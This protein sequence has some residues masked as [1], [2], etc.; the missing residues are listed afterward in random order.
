MIAPERYR[1]R[2]VEE[3]YEGMGLMKSLAISFICWPGLNE[4]IEQLRCNNPR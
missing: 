3:L 2:I 4:D 1:E